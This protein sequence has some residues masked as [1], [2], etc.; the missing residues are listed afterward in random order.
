MSS[1]V[2]KV[3]VDPI[4]Q[5]ENE[6]S[7]SEQKEKP[8]GY[9]LSGDQQDIG[10][11]KQRLPDQRGQKAEKEGSAHVTHTSDHDEQE[12]LPFIPTGSFSHQDEREPVVGKS[13]VKKRDTDRCRRDAAERAV[14][15]HAGIITN[16]ASENKISG[17][18]SV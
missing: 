1:V 14:R 17:S 3:M 10:Q 5:A 13:S 6:V 9:S 15:E 8:S 12:D 7:K 2:V 4:T 16:G 18:G 11:W